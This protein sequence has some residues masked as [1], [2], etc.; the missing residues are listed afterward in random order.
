M[1]EKIKRILLDEDLKEALPL[2]NVFLKRM[3]EQ[4]NKGMKSHLDNS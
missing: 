2:I 3:V 4:S 1:E